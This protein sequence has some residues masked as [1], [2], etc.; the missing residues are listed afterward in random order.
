MDRISDG[1][2]NGH[3]MHESLVVVEQMDARDAIAWLRRTEETL[4]VNIQRAADNVIGRLEEHHGLVLNDVQKGVLMRTVITTAVAAV[5][6]LRSGHYLMWRDLVQGTALSLF[7]PLLG[8]RRRV[9]GPGVP[10]QRRS[11]AGSHRPPAGKVSDPDG[12]VINATKFGFVACSP[13]TDA[14]DSTIRL[15]LLTTANPN[16]TYRHEAVSLQDG[17]CL[18]KT[19]VDGLSKVGSSLAAAAWPA[20]CGPDPNFDPGGPDDEDEGSDGQNGDG[21]VPA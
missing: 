18:L 2:V 20:V 12:N 1:V 5:T 3:L 19:L 16:G 21:G 6:A 10:P 11:K 14:A 7:D 13:A 4:A 15:L 17:E 9:A 8:V